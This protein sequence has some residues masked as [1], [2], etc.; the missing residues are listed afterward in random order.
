MPESTY[1]LQKVRFPKA[2]SLSFSKTLRS[3]VN[4]YFKEKSL[5]PK[6]NTA[7]FMKT[8]A[9][10]AMYFLPYLALFIFN[11]GPWAVLGLFA[12]MG[13]GMSGVG[14]SVMHDAAHGA[15]HRSPKVNDFIASSIYLISGNLTTW[16]LQHNVLHHT[17]TNIDGLDDDLDTH[18]LLR[19]HPDQPLHKRH[20]YQVWYA[21][22]LYSLLT[23]NWVVM[24][25][26]SQ[27][28]RYQ[29][30]GVAKLSDDALRQEWIKLIYTK[31]LYFGLFLVLPIVF[32]AV[33]WYIAVLGFVIMHLIAGFVLSF[34]FQLAH[35]V[36]HV[37]VAH[38]PEDDKAMDDEFLAHQLKTTSDFARGNKLV[39]WFVG[40]LNFQVEHH[41]FPHICHIHYPAL[42]EIVKKT[43][44]EFNLPYYEHRT[45][46][47]AIRA[48]LRSLKLYGNAS[49]SA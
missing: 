1:P 23:L 37:Q 28:I 18:G 49:L 40:G 6:A 14:M 8:V 45:L 16:R 44:Q 24:K 9:M 12:I 27:L 20:R 26:F 29:K 39:G 21:P 35:V 32:L 42:S 3:R 5:N 7:M 43:A 4:Q 38:I 2:D 34:V 36:D 48:H 10:L 17:Y 15:Y 46:G 13:M 33:P 19:L 11:P 31:V 47:Q 30:T 22:L 25:D 41:L